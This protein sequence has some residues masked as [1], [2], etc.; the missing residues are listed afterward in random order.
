MKRTALLVALVAAALLAGAAPAQAAFGFLPGDAGF[1][2]AVSEPDGDPAN[3]AGS[4][5]G[6]LT[7]RA[8]FDLEPSG[9][10]DGDLKGFSIDL[11]P[12]LIENPRAV[13][14]CSQADFST[15]RSSPFEAS[16]SGESCPEATQVGV[17][18]IES[19]T[20]T[21][22]FG[23]FNLVPAPGHPARIGFS[24]YGAPVFFVPE[25]RQG[26]G[27]YG[28]TLISRG[29]PQLFD[30]RAI[31]LTL[32]GD[33]WAATH[34]G[35][36][37]NC[38]N[39]TDSGTAH[40]QCAPQESHARRAY[41][42]L[43]SSC[44]GPLAFSAQA[45]SWQAPGDFEAAQFQY[46]ALQGCDQLGFPS[47][48]TVT[49]SAATVSSPTGL[50]VRLET[51]QGGAALT[52]PGAR[53]SSQVKRA[54]IALPE[55]LTINP[56]VGAGLGSCSVAQF[57]TETAGSPPG[58]GCPNPS[59]VGTATLETPLVEGALNGSLFIATPFANPFGSAYAIY[60]LARS[61][62]RGFIVKVAGWLDADPRTGQLTAT[63]DDLPQLPYANLRIE[64]REGQRAPLVTPAACGTYTSQISLSP[65]IDPA[66]TVSQSSKFSLVRGITAGGA[67]PTG[68]APFAPRA[69]AGTLNA[70]AGSAS[71]FYLHLTRT[72]PEQEITSYSTQ[73]PPGLLGAIAGIP[74][75]ADAAIEAAKARSGSAEAQSPSCPEASRIGRTFSG[76]GAGLAPAYAPGKVYL[77]GPYRGA[78]LSV[79]AI[80]PAIVGPFDLGTVVVRSAIQVDSRTAQVTVDSSAS[81]PIPHIFSGIPLRLR[82]IRLHIDRPGFMRNP[83]SCAPFSIASTLTG[84][85]VPFTNPRGVVATPAVPYQLSNC[86]ALKFAPA[87]ALRASG[88][89][90]RGDHQRLQVVVTPR[91]GN[92]NIAMA[93]VTLPPS[94]FLEQEN[95]RG[96]CTR[97]QFAV[98]TCPATSVVGAAR[99]ETPLLEAPLEG[100]V[101]LRSSDNPLPDL[102]AVL[103]GRGVRIV[104]EGRVDSHRGGLRG[105]FEGLPDAPVSRFVMTIFGGRKRGI[106]ISAENLCRVPQ[107]AEARFAGQ[108]NGASVQQPKL[109]AK[110]PKKKG[111]RGRGRGR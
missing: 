21:R 102:V 3:L 38:L 72:D 74:F 18:A 45:D 19:A 17:V 67:C 27:E 70:N 41:L 61:A 68:G 42:T 55:G 8:A 84:S 28:L 32:W 58:A 57:A 1:S 23:V 56:S 99:A 14:Q 78:P 101:L 25:V 91:P 85:D 11:P 44:T 47:L 100:P 53:L 65:W 24:P 89:T 86:S 82:D 29:F 66:A 54:V 110:C 49:A 79:A 96:I 26:E 4:H 76:Y 37:G 36:R 39:E 106:L 69:T 98:D 6:V 30:T 51:F 13:P 16:R 7:V 50:S 40:G 77:A 35:E 90:K 93:A 95:I 33:P 71:A 22:S 73:L 31:E 59:K 109:R 83:T 75:C 43:P 12:G 52:A 34:D 2:V 64:F 63:F 80:N 5:P 87:I 60:F 20:G 108:N 88:G 48:A 104:L 107:L 92:A 62:E 97:A 46:P 103:R 15:P 81:D 94:I 105:R 10:P 9:Y 111:K